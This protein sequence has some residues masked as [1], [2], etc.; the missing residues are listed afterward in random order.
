MQGFEP[1]TPTAVQG[2]RE[3]RFSAHEFDKLIGDPCQTQADPML[4]ALAAM[5]AAVKSSNRRARSVSAM[6]IPVSLTSKRKADSPPR[7]L[8]TT[9]AAGTFLAAL[10]K[11]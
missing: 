5:R 9:L 11:H 10:I 2:A 1:E 6:P 3:F 7:G 4:R 8:P